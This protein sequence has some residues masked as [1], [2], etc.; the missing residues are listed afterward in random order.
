MSAR[1]LP[2][3]R[4]ALGTDAGEEFDPAVRDQHAPGPLPLLPE[5]CPRARDSL[6]SE[7][8]FTALGPRPDPITSLYP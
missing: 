5:H 4:F 2:G 8:D 7:G 6:V 1:V 3:G